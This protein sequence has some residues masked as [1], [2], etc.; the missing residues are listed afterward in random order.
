MERS[1]RF[2]L[3]LTV[4]HWRGDNIRAVYF[5]PLSQ[6]SCALHKMCELGLSHFFFYSWLAFVR[7]ARV[8]EATIVCIM[9]TIVRDPSGHAVVLIRITCVMREFTR[10]PNISARSGNASP[11]TGIT[12]P[13]EIKLS[14]FPTKYCNVVT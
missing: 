13:P 1:F 4:I 5:S 2:M 8:K 11:S 3:Y 6:C 14:L 7:G 12:H 9:E 10:L